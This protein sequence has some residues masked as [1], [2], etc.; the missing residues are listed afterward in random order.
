MPCSTRGSGHGSL[1]TRRAVGTGETVLDVSHLRVGFRTES[2]RPQAVDD[3]S[4]ALH[5]GEVLS[6]VGESGSG[7]SVS[8]MTLMGLTRV[9]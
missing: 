3:V 8:A 2:G 5:R 4:F 1:I 9:A 6:I 7:K